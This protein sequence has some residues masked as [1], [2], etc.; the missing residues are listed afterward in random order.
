MSEQTR[1]SLSYASDFLTFL[2]LERSV[3]ERIISIYL[4]GS[5]VRGELSEDG[6]IDLFINCSK[7]N[8]KIVLKAAETAEKR[9]RSSK[10]FD[11]W[12]K[13]GFTYPIAIKA[14][15]LDEWEL[16]ESIESEGIVIFSKSLQP[17][18]LERVVIFLLDLPK[19]KKAYLVLTRKLFGRKER[20][21][22]TEG[23]VSKKNGER[24]G[25]NSLIV[26]KS[27]QHE[28]IEILHKHKT[29]FRMLELF[30]KKT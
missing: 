12:E 9:F 18:G 16:K 21:F 29:S 20:G 15:P 13:F 23:I 7:D 6:D 27:S 3:E 2:F 17:K 25:P 14:G 24:L 11:K 10:D 8:E 5:S 26:S 4:F 19:D 1:K 22:K 30:R 28:I